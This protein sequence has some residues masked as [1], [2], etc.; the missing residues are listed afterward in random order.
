MAVFYG[1]FP[2]LNFRELCL[3]G[4]ASGEVKVL[5]PLVDLGHLCSLRG[6]SFHWGSQLS[7]KGA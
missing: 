5:D 2:F 6:A 7:S 1:L 4:G 3:F